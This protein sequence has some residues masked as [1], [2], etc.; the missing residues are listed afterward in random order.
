MKKEP[1]LDYLQVALSNPPEVYQEI[2]LLRI[3]VTFED[4]TKVRWAG[5]EDDT[6]GPDLG[7]LG[8]QG[9]VEEVGAGPEV[10]EGEGDVGAVV[11][12]S[13]TVLVRRTHLVDVVDLVDVPDL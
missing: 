9:D 3:S 5:R 10:L 6:V 13:Q 7:L 1:L 11:V 4:F 12:P 2:L 8:G